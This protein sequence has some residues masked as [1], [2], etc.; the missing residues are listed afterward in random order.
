MQRLRLALGCA[1]RGRHGGYYYGTHDG[2][3][4]TVLTVSV[5]AEQTEKAGT[6]EHIG[7]ELITGRRV[8]REQ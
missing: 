4:V 1:E 5:V 2:S 3:H 6:Q 8:Q 7:V